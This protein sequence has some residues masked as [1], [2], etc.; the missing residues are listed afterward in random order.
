[1]KSMAGLHHSVDAVGL[2][3]GRVD[4]R[5]AVSSVGSARRYRQG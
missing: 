5:D 2:N 4:F 1:M 3:G